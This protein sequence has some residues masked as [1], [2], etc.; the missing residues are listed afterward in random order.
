VESLRQAEE[1]LNRKE[2]DISC[3]NFPLFDVP[4]TLAQL[5]F[6]VIKQCTIS[7]LLVL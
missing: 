1:N 2:K 3:A 5:P 6:K 7:H 4:T